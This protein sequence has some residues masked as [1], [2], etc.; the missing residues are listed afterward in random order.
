M[1]SCLYLQLVHIFRAVTVICISFQAPTRHRRRRGRSQ[2]AA[3]DDRSRGIG[4]HLS[5]SGGPGDGHFI[6]LE[7]LPTKLGLFVG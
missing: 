5:S 1:G 4:G 2:D 3:F 6:L 7:D